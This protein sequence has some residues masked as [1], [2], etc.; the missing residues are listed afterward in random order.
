MAKATYEGLRK[1]DEKRPYVITR[2]CYSGSQKYTTAW[3]GDNHSIWAHLQMAIPQLCNLGMSGMAFAGTDVGGFGSD[4]T[5][6][7][8]SRWVQV[9][10][11]SP[12]FRNHSAMGTSRQEPWAFNQETLEINRRYIKLRYRMLPYLYD[13]YRICSSNGVPVMRPL[14]MEYPKD[15]NVRDMND[16]FL[17][18]SQILVAPVVNQGQRVRSVYLPEGEWIDFWT[19]ESFM[20][21]RYILK[22]APLDICPI[23]IKAGSILPNY[24]ELKYVGEKEITELTLDLYSGNGE[25]LHYQDN[26]EDFDYQKGNYNEYYFFLE[27][28]QL[29]IKMV[30]RGYEKIYSSFRILWKGQ[31]K[32]IGF[33]GEPITIRLS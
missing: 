12:F 32:C 19:K 25:Y 5:P 8:L 20:G 29:E 15:A 2:A 24:P 11:F 33:N 30:H 3:T 16:Q 18:G 23:Y 7:L 22:E 26:G 13:L 31:E 17:L 21:G 1:H 14:V 10:C 28:E 27:D 9:G 4:C 6:E